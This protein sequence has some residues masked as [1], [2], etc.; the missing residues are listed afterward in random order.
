VI[1]EDAGFTY[2]GADSVGAVLVQEIAIEE[3]LRHVLGDRSG[4]AT[5]ARDLERMLVD[6][7]RED[8]QLRRDTR[9][10]HELAKQD[11][12]GIGLLAGGAAGHP[13]PDRIVLPLGFEQARDDIPF[14][15]LEDGRIAKEVGDP[16][17][18]ILKQEIDLARFLAQPIEKS[19]DIVDLQDLH[20]P[21]HTPQD[22]L[23][24][25]AAEV[26]PGARPQQSTELAEG[27]RGF[28]A[29]SVRS[30]RRVD[31]GRRRK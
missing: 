16:D 30:V 13:D 11:G 1:R 26:V 14:E 31:R 15:S 9:I 20:A 27:F 18:E 6:I 24:L 5:G 2:I 25:V 7:G 12:D 21:Q 4:V 3:L 17:Q 28:P 19:G 22:R 23:V 8:L 29:F 10:R